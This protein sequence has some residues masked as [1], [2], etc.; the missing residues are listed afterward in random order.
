M[1]LE[2]ATIQRYNPKSYTPEGEPIEVLFN[3]TEYRLNV[4]NQ[5]SQVDV[6]GLQAPRIQFGRG[7]ASTLSMRLFFDTY[8]QGEDVRT[9]TDQIISL[10]KVDPDLHEPPICLFSWGDLNFVC[11]LERADQSFVLFRSDGVPVRATVNV[12]F[13]QYY[14]AEKQIG[15]QQ[16]A[17]FAKRYVVRRGDTLSSIAGRMYGDP[18]LWRPIAKENDMDDPL[19]IRPGQ[20]LV[21]P[22][23]E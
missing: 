19:A 14:E 2:K 5:F 3:P 13:K 17:D 18:A 16:S 12:T 6:P 1:G 11:V 9:H 21:I 23:V 22:A 7:N 20:V 4:S 8:E 10:L 15:K